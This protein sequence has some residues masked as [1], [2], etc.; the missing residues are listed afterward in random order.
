MVRK[1]LEAIGVDPSLA[2]SARV[3]DQA[4]AH[5]SRRIN[6][7]LMEHRML[8]AELA[9]KADLPRDS[10]SRYLLKKSVPSEASLR[11]LAK[12][13]GCEVNDLVPSRS[14]VLV[15]PENANLELVT[16]PDKPGMAF[17]RIAQSMPMATAQKIIAML[18][19]DETDGKRGR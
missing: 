1:P 11:Q 12:A 18:H 13:M 7:F 16:M 4:K 14:E 19:N 15:D 5:L 17:L 9:R 8:P 6:I 3:R 10:I 2:V